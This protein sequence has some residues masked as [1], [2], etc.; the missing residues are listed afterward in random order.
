MIL[1]HCSTNLD[2]YKIEK[3][4]NKMC[5]RPNEGDIVR[6]KSGKIL[7]IDRITHAMQHS[8]GTPILEI[9]LHLVR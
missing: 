6:A 8:T 4:P 3:W 7:R 1:I 2:D 9:E 5:C